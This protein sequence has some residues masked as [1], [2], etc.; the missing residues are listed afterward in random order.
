LN[1]D[2][3]YT[4]SVRIV[5]TNA[6]AVGT[7]NKSNIRIIIEHNNESPYANLFE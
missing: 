1:G 2:G 3:G 6:N 4:S 5:L 7:E